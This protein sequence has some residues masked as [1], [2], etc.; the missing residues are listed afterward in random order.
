[1]KSPRRTHGEAYP[2]LLGEKKGSTFQ[3]VKTDQDLRKSS[4]VA[5]T[6]WNKIPPLTTFWISGF[7]FLMPHMEVIMI[8]TP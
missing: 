5:K 3:I 1:M 4:S 2:L 6:A 8:P 7:H